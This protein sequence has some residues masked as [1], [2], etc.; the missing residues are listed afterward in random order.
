[1]SPRLL[2][3]AV[4]LFL[5]SGCERPA[6]PDAA[7]MGPLAS[8]LT[9]LSGAVE[10]TVRYESP[11]A[12]AADEALLKLATAAD[13]G[14]TTPFEGYIL[15]AR[16]EAGHAVLLLCERDRALLEDLGCTGPLETAHWQSAVK[17]ACAFTLKAE[18]CG[19]APGVVSPASP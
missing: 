15:R 8:A 2:S 16:Q 14:L 6:Q 9:K 7:R 18:A 19:G 4:V 17:A 12:D 3:A 13:P 1:M 10:A 11:P 5:A